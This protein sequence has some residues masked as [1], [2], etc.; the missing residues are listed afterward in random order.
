M[1]TTVDQMV[2]SFAQPVIPPI[3]GTP[4]YETLSV[5]FR[6]LSANATSV[7]CPLGNGQLGWLRIT[8]NEDLYNSL[9]NTPFVAPINPGYAP[10]LPAFPTAN[11][12]SLL[13]A[14]HKE[15]L[16]LWN[17][18]NTI[19]RAL[20]HQL[21]GAVEGKFISA[22]RNR[23]TGF[24]T[25][26][27][28]TIMEHLLYT[29]GRIL[30]SEIVRNDGLFR[31]PFDANEPIETLYEQIEDAM[32]LAT[33]A[34]AAYNE[35]Q[36]LA[37]AL[38]LVQCTKMY[39]QACHEWTRKA[40]N[41]KTWQNFKTHFTEAANE[42]RED[43]TTGQETGYHPHPTANNAMAD[44]T[45][46]TAEAFANLA[47]ATAADRGMMA[48]L[49]ATNKTL[50]DQLSLLTQEVASLR[51][52][53]QGHN[54]RSNP[55]AAQHGGNNGGGRLRKRYHNQNYCWTHGF[56]LTRNHDSTNCRFPADGHK[57]DATRTNNL[58]G[59]QTNKDRT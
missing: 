6:I 25:L 16:R 9:S 59:S 14:T 30:P 52:N 58:G 43:Q 54:Q 10:N 23:I 41:D 48:D 29:Y 12:V 5:I 56:D 50:L 26:S 49:M 15:Q 33:D 4:N 7:P 31:K 53:Q 45:Q 8:I 42:L 28:R 2:E 37:N 20:K 47:T 55:P 40:D 46:E 32:Q 57:T 34:N 13:Q 18:Y 21:I 38:N 3:I 39:R 36:V 17:E 51:N 22:I 19:D 44:F 35:N 24:S 27:T 11:Q 1:A